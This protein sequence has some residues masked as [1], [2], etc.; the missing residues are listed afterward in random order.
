MNSLSFKIMPLA[1]SCHM[2]IAI[3][4]Y[5]STQIYPLSID[6]SNDTLYDKGIIKRMCS[7]FGIIF[8]VGGICV[9]CFTIFRSVVERIIEMVWKWKFERYLESDK[10][11]FTEMK[12][13]IAKN[14]LV[15][16]DIWKNPKYK[17]VLNE[18]KRDINSM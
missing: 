8:F 15:T 16:Y 6:E 4:V 13:K 10:I 18:V 12:E 9:F 17:L 1:L 11:N 3:F 5:T 2:F 14:G 7:K